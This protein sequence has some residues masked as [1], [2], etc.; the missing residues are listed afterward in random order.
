MLIKNLTYKKILLGVFGSVVLGLFWS[1][2][3]LI[4]WSYYSLEEN[5]TTCSVEWKDQSPNVLSYNVCMFIFVF[6]VPLSIIVFTSYRL[7]QTVSIDF[8]ITQN[9]HF[10]IDI[11]TCCQKR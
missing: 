4:G 9:S 8:M 6:F 2:M 7:L 1:I 5:F 10:V 3:P 11:F